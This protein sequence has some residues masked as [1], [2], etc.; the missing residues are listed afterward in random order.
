[1][2]EGWS[3][4]AQA[5]EELVETDGNVLKS[6]RAKAAF[7]KRGECSGAVTP[8]EDQKVGQP[9]VLCRRLGGQEACKGLTVNL[10]RRVFTH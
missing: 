1:M 6:G 4:N 2:Q 9:K 8:N 10:G 5:H 3:S 7:A